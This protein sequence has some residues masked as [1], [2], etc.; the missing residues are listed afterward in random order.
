MC[1]VTGSDDGEDGQTCP[2]VEWKLGRWLGRGL[3]ESVVDVEGQT[4]R[5]RAPR[6]P[7][8]PVDRPQRVVHFVLRVAASKIRIII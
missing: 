3:A 1:S 8:G 2:V 7:R 6:S 5:V 4:D